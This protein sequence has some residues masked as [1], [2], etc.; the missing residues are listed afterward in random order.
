MRQTVRKMEQMPFDGLFST[1]VSSGKGGIL[2]HENG[3]AASLTGG[4][5][6]RD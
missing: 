6:A 3:A 4:M 2:S 5:S 1:H